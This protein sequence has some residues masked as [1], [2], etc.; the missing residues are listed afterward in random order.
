MDI[1]GPKVRMSRAERTPGSNSEQLAWNIQEQE[2]SQHGQS[3]VR[4]KVI[5]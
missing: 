5:K 4:E 1:G 2:K 3:E